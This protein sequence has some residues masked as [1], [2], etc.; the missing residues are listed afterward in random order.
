MGDQVDRSCPRPRWS[1]TRSRQR[2]RP[3]QGARPATGAGAFLATGA[4]GRHVRAAAGRVDPARE[5]PGRVE[6]VW[7]GPAREAD[8][9]RGEA[10]AR[11]RSEVADALKHHARANE[12]SKGPTRKTGVASQ[13]NLPPSL[14]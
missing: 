14:A 6:P 5:E 4:A 9:G 2:S 12:D 1:P 8:G 11:D 13:R 7:V 3:P 10:L